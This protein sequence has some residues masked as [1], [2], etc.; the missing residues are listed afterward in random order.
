MNIEV[1]INPGGVTQTILGIPGPKGAQGDQGIQGPPGS[2]GDIAV[3]EEF[4][5]GEPVNTDY[6]A[7]RGADLFTNG[8]GL[9]GNNY[10]VTDDFAFDPVVTPNLPGSF[11]FDGYYGGLFVTSEFLPVNPNSIYRLQTYLMQ[12]GLSGDWSAYAYEERHRQYMGVHC[13]DVDG[14]LINSD[15]YMRHKHDGTDSLTTL[16]AP[17]TPGDAT[18]TVA[19]ASGWNENDSTVYRRGV[20]IFEY[21]NAAGYKYDY[22]SRLHQR[23]LFDL[24]G[25]NKSTNVI[26]LNQGFPAALGNPHD[27]NGTWPVG[28]KIANDSYG[29]YKYSLLAGQ[30]TPAA[31]TWYRVT[32]YIGGIDVSGE[33]TEHN[34]PPGTAFAKLFMMPNYSNRSGGWTAFPDTGAEHSMWL[35][36]ISVAPEPQGVVIADAGGTKGLKVPKA[37]LSTNVMDVVT[38]GQTVEPV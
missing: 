24:G 18:I 7:S 32:N 36:G 27:A 5:P 31:D 22:Y 38:A 8:T 29:G 23:A 20:I 34:F 15:N 28:T 17:L 13:Y 4:G 26:T 33:N 25:V 6:V 14:N 10:N 30:V 9:L 11:R 2:D 1:I 21:K 16:A 12:E 3:P 37:N 35:A 19:D